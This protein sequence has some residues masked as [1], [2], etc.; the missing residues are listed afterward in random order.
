MRYRL[1]I[2]AALAVLAASF[3]LFTVI[4]GAGW[5][6]AAIGAVVVAAGAGLAMRVGGIPAAATATGLMLIA[7]MPLLA[8]PTWLG[9]IG[10]LVLVA[11][12]A[13]SAVTRRV[14][15]ALADA[16]AYLAALFLY[17]NLVF[18]GS[19]SWGLIIPTARSV[20]HLGNLVS[21]GYAEHIYAPPVPGVRGLEL[22]AGA[23]VGVVAILTD[24]IAVRLRSPAVA[25]LPLLVLFSVPVATNVKDVGLGLT[26]AFCLGITGYLAL[27]SADGRDRLRLWGRLVTVWQ[28]TPEDEDARGPDTRVLAA[29]GRRIG[30]AAVALAVIVPLALPSVK[31]HGLFGT[32]PAPGSSG[33]GI[34]VAPPQPLVLMR[35]QLLAHASVPVLTYRTDAKQPSQQYLQMYV[36]NYDGKSA[37]TLQSRTPSTSV[38]GQ[39]LP[40]APGLAPDTDF[41]TTHTTITIGR[42]S[43]TG[44]VS[45]LPAPYAPQ[46][47]TGEGAGWQETRATLMLYGFKPDAGLHYTVISRT[48]QPTQAQRQAGGRIP[49]R[50]RQA[51][52][53]YPGPDRARLIQIAD[54][55]A[56]VAHTPFSRALALQDYFTAPGRF[57]YAL[58][59]G[60]P[61]SVLQF[62]TTDRRGFCQQFAFSMAVLA[63]LL[64]IP[65]RVAVGYTAGSPQRGGSWQVTTADA[66]AWPE[67]YFPRTGWLR[68][69]PTPGGLGG[70]GTAT[71]PA[72][73][74]G[75]GVG[76]STGPGQNLN[77]PPVLPVGPTGK[78]QPGGI[79][80]PI[81]ENNGQASGS[82]GAAGGG[83]PILLVALLVIAA[84]LIAPGLGR[85]VT[86]RRRWL[87]A[88]G[89]AGRAHAAW[90]ELTSDLVDLGLGGAASESPRALARRVAASAGLDGPARE[91]LD[92]MAAAEERARYARTPAAGETLRADGKTVRRAVARALTGQQRW[93]ARLLPASTLNPVGAWLREAADV[94]GWMDA[95]GLRIRH[96]I[97]GAARPRR[98]D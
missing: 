73:S 88:S 22:I 74:G 52:L 3:S 41:A 26:V 32:N 83:F 96:T 55:I 67:L 94:F 37:W 82:G 6:Y 33:G 2:T 57:K 39:V 5:L 25:G 38:E 11:A 69:E 40:P 56:G 14:L 62:L 93:R 86:R 45:Y 60:L 63:R 98:A 64:G 4:S 15:P 10:G 97:G 35:N 92:R 65:S 75:T 91:A 53:S 1:T 89:D 43:A 23:G 31:E 76:G 21:A 70:Q 90:R 44:T 27:L 13:G 12:M 59:G 8:G 80:K 50:I 95:A 85:V 19:Q 51:Y 30:L 42:N 58:R 17:L 84:L 16:G 54:R 20:R 29:S 46:I 48:A 36:M 66:H 28:D 71:Q 34:K 24:L 47:V 68:F 77:V 79:N 9:R 7:V 18:A 61:T 78:A 87:G 81:G 49:A 72:Y